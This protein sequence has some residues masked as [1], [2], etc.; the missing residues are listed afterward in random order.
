MEETKPTPLRD[1]AVLNMLVSILLVL[2]VGSA[3]YLA[4]RVP[5]P[6]GRESLIEVSIQDVE[7]EP[8]VSSNA[9]SD[10][11]RYIQDFFGVNVRV[12]G[13]DDVTLVGA[14]AFEIHH[15]ISIPIILLE[16]PHG[17]VNWMFAFTYALL[18]DWSAGIF[19]D[20]SVRLELEHDGSFAVISAADGREIVLWRSG[21]DIFLA[22]AQKGASRLISRISS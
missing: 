1:G 18:D 15:G 22:V 19:L 5:P 4:S 2:M 13:I 7:V 8:V 12:P 10:T 16:D 3:A 20:R 17:D 6:P 9:P 21:D 14:G 11:E